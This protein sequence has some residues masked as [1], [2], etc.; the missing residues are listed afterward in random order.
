MKNHFVCRSLCVLTV[1]AASVGI[2]GA[3]QSRPS[4]DAPPAAQSNQA[5]SSART[6]GNQQ[7]TGM[8]VR[9]GQTLMLKDNY[10]VLTYKLDDQNKAQEYVGK[11]V[12]INGTLDSANRVLH[13]QS[14]EPGS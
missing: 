14:I 1:S 13:V 7:F 3:Q 8:V 2:L 5:Q 10:G 9:Q 11:R 4:P 12:K 6:T